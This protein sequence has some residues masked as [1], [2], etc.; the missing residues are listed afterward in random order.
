MS[1]EERPVFGVGL[2][3]DGARVLLLGITKGTWDTIQNGMSK[4][5]DLSSI[6]I[7][8]KVLIFGADTHADVMKIIN[9]TFAQAGIPVL[10]ERR[11]DFSSGGN[12]KG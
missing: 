3:N 4:D 10:D 12:L 11:K 6:G 5:I 2:G 9:E 8:L 7:P 1:I